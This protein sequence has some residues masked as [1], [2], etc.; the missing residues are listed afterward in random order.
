MDFLDEP[1]EFLFLFFFSP[2]PSCKGV[3]FAVPFKS[4][5][6]EEIMLTSVM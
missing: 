3:P 4:C 2:D 1:S 6:A 5:L